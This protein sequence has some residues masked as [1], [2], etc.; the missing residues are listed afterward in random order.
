VAGRRTLRDGRD[1][2]VERLALAIIELATDRGGEVG[3]GNAVE[4]IPRSLLNLVQASK[5]RL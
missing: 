3:G 1:D 4:L 5:N 2:P